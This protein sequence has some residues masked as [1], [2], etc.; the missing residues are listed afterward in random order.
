MGQ[1][2]AIE[3]RYKGYRF[4]SRAE[5]RWAVFFDTLGLKYVYEPEGFELPCGRYLPDFLLPEIDYWFEVKGQKPTPDEV[6][7]CGFLYDATQRPVILAV[8]PPS[9]EPQLLRIPLFWVEEDA[10]ADIL[11]PRFVFADD[12]RNE[13]QFWL[14]D[15]ENPEAHCLGPDTGRDHDRWPLIHSATQRGYTAARAAR[16]E[17][18]R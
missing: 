12:R 8:G 3:T 6:V 15:D 18:D 16:F 9:P 7:K 14:L 13:R 2:K 4:R 11:A 1:I 10:G 17:F 5:A